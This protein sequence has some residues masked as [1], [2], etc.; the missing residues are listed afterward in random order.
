[1]VMNRFRSAKADLLIAT[2]VAARGLDIQQLSH[3]FNYDVPSSPE[4][5]VHRIGR[6][7][8]AGREGTAVTLAEPRE[9]RLLKSIERFTKQKIDMESLPTVADLRAKRL[10][11]TRASVHERLLSG[12]YEDVRVVVESLAQEFDIVDVAAAAIKA[13]HQAAVG[14]GTDGEEERDLPAPAIPREE[15]FRGSA[16]GPRT[17]RPR[18]RDDGRPTARVFIGAGRQAGIRPADLVGAITNEAGIQ[19]R[20]LGAIEITDRFSLVELPEDVVDQVVDAMRKA[21]LRGQKVPVRR[22]RDS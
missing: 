6:T 16:A 4:V 13:A 11:L 17:P 14:D 5:Y 12:D 20:D 8:R 7:G 1:M 22:D 3:V 21:T 15:R 18:P 19:S 10:E 9:H 2:D